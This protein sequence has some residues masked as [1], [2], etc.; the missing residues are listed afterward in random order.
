M[1]EQWGVWILLDPTGIYVNIY[2][3]DTICIK[4]ICARF[5]EINIREWWILD[6]LIS[7]RLTKLIWKFWKGKHYF[8]N[9]HNKC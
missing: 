1:G 5:F 2:F 3:I 6:M 8:R 7:I 4:Q 9:I